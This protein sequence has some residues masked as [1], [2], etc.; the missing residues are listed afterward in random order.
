M[1][2][3]TLYLEIT[4]QCNLNCKT[5]YNR[6]GLNR[7]RKELSAEQVEG[8]IQTFLS[9]GLKRVLLSG[10]EP[11]L[12]T[13][14]PL[15]LELPKKFPQLEFG[16]VTNGTVLREDFLN[17]INQKKFTVQVSLDGSDEVSNALTRG[18]GNFQRTLSFIRRIESPKVPVRLKCVLSQQNLDKLEDFYALAVSLNCIP[19]FAYIY[20]SGNGDDGWEHKALSARQKIQV[21]E[22]ILRLNKSFDMDAFLPE[23]TETCPFAVGNTEQLSL[24]IRT[25][26]SVQPCQMLY[27]NDFTLTN[28]LYFNEAEFCRNLDLLCEAAARRRTADYNCSRCPL[29]QACGRGC[30]A[31]AEYLHGTLDSHDGDC[32]FR[33][34]RFFS[35]IGR[36]L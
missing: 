28:A 19:E 8:I 36:R 14:F 20:R 7:V 6:S 4:N 18:V 13:E 12:H 2:T 5:C 25:D 30:P 22:H 26:G 33:Q 23:C 11:T 16:I 15:F 1:R 34:I 10:G 24:C 35:I 3:E 17:A 29:R 21:I 31:L 9:Y 27:G 32:E